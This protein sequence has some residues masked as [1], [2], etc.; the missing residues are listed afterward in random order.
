[1]TDCGP[2]HESCCASLPVPGGTFF[3]AYDSALGGRCC[4]NPVFAADGGPTGEAD[5]ATVSPFR[6]DKYLVTVARYRQFEA[7]WRAG[8]GW[9]PPAGSGK[10]AHL[11]GGR[12]LVEQGAEGGL[13]YEP[14]WLGSYDAYLGVCANGSCSVTTS[15]W[16]ITPGSAQNRPI[17]MVNWFDAYAFC[18]WDGGFL[19]SQAEWEFAA[20]GGDEQR[21][22]P[23]VFI[24]GGAGLT[25]AIAD[26]DY[27]PGTNGCT[28]SS[29]DNIA[30]VGTPTAGAGRWGQLDLAG[31]VVQ[32][33]LDWQG[34]VNPCDDCATLTPVAQT[35]Q[36]ASNGTAFDGLVMPPPW[37]GQ[38]VPF[39]RFDYVGFRC[40]RV[41]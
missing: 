18:I 39:Y 32:W 7:A 1:M 26:C 27:P 36:R 29:P 25:Y 37:T 19:P 24:D 17:N 5:P 20:A 9:T 33:N 10:H 31:E 30:P 6:L 38:E 14:G 8:A 11:N 21:R 3:R 12:G 41:P 23:W 22:A 34:R 40:A 28:N 35:P 15:T 2:N 16:T 13:T 4:P